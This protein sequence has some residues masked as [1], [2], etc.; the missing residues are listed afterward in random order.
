[1][2]EHY[3]Y[4]F[5]GK[6]YSH[7]HTTYSVFFT[8]KDLIIAQAF[9]QALYCLAYYPSV[10]MQ[11]LVQTQQACFTPFTNFMEVAN[12]KGLKGVFSGFS[13]YFVYWMGESF[14]RFYLGFGYLNTFALSLLSG[15]FY[16]FELQQIRL[17][18]ATLSEMGIGT[19][20]L[21]D[22]IMNYSNPKYWTGFI[23]S[24][25]RNYALYS[26]ITSSIILGSIMPFA[27]SIP[28][29]VAMDNIRRCMVA[30]KFDPAS[31]LKPTYYEV[32]LHITSNYGWQGL[33]RGF[34]I[35]PHIYFVLAA[36]IL[37]PWKPFFLI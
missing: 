25:V 30:F 34:L 26:G 11:T 3:H 21:K 28:A 16:P 13:P 9:S 17:S 12:L 2:V 24:V 4:G 37:P 10:R 7:M 1:M 29:M 27:F 15:V 18:A 14:T 8:E 6:P 5:N 19:S 23:F 36:L 22:V 31:I 20:P 33:F 35:Y 32:Y